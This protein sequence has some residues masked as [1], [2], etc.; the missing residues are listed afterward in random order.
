MKTKG[1]LEAEISTQTGERI[2][3]FSLNGPIT[4]KA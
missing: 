3:V 4:V 1:Q 2:I